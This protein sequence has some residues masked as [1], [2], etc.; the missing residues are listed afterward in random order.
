MDSDAQNAI[1]KYRKKHPEYK[2][3]NREI[4][5]KK[6][7]SGESVYDL[8]VSDVVDATVVSC[9]KCNGKVS[10]ETI[11]KDTVDIPE[12][13]KAKKVRN[14]YSVGKCENGHQIDTT[15]KGLTKG[16]VFGPHIMG[17]IVFMFFQTLSMASICRMLAS[18]GLNVSKST[19]LKAIVAVS[20]EKF[21]VRATEISKKLKESKFLMADEARIK[22]G[23]KRN[24]S[25][26]CSV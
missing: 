9:E 6:N 21:A 25:T 11:T 1:Q 3:I 10:V 20:K 12:M 23:K 13:P 14:V 18:F 19:V 7:G 15:P 8:E 17:M 5:S 26:F 16:S 22:I 24:T 2:E 4:E